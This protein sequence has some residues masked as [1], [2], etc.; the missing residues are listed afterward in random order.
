MSQTSIENA[1]TGSVEVGV[2]DGPANTG[3]VNPAVGPTAYLAEHPIKIREL[4]V[5]RTER[6]TPKLVRVVFGGANVAGFESHCSDEHVKLVFPDPETG[7]T[8]APVQAGDRLE[9][10]RPFPPTRE[11]TIR[12]YD[13][14]AG[15]VV[16]D[17]VVH[18]GGLASDWAEQAEP[19]RTLWVAGPRPS[20]VVP[21]E[22]GFRL[23]LG[24][25][26]ALPAV[27]RILEELPVTAHARVAVLIP[28]AAERQPLAI[29]DGV[30]VSWLRL[31]DPDR[32]RH[33][34]DAFLA[35]TTLPADRHTYLWAAGEA[36]LMRPV[37]R[38]AKEHGFARGNCDIAGYWRRSRGSGLTDRQSESG[39]PK[40]R[41]MQVS[42]LDHED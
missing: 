13:A 40:H 14:E 10:P 16:I 20:Y 31:D 9:W 33:S 3:A 11:Y 35:E 38:W 30:E 4:E 36:G 12:R 28:D 15:E 17:F 42:G 19:G 29:R 7:R 25:H 18:Q 26:T 39:R 37:R 2:T 32:T 41:G 5:L 23:V 6:V 34:F 27:A 1:V 8:R 22:F 21:E 24:D